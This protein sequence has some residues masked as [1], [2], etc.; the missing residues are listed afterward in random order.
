MKDVLQVYM[1]V[2]AGK[3]FVVTLITVITT[4]TPLTPTRWHRPSPTL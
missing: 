4:S 1:T 3:E 2:M